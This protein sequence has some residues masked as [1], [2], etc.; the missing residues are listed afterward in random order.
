MISHNFRYAKLQGRSFKGKNLDGANFSNADIRGADFTNA[1]LIGAN[2]KYAKAGLQRRWV[3]GLIIGSWF[4]AAIAGFIS[5]YSSGFAIDILRQQ[6]F[7]FFSSAVSLIIWG[8]FLLV[9]FYKG[10]GAA[11]GSLAVTVATAMAILAAP[12][13]GATFVNSIVLPIAVA[14]NVAGI[15]DGAIALAITR[16]IVKKHLNY[17]L[18]TQLMIALVGTLF[19]VTFGLTGDSFQD[20][21]LAITIAIATAIFLISA[22]T[23]IGW[24]AISEN[25]KY[26]IIKSVAISVSA[27]FGTKFQGANLTDANFTQATLK[28][29]DFR[30][31]TLKRTR[32]FNAKK[33]EQAYV[34]GTYLANETIRKLII[35]KDG[36]GRD[37]NY[38]NM[39]GINLQGANLKNAS[40]IE[41]N[42]SE[43]TLE[44]SNLSQAKL[45]R[46]QLYGTNLGSACLTGAYIQDWGISTDT[47]FSKVECDYIFMRLPTDNDP[48]P[49]RKPDNKSETFKKGDFADFITPII[50]TLDLYQKQNFDP[51]QVA[52]Q[53]KS[54][55][56]YH[57]RGIDPTAAT[58]AIKKIAAKYPESGLKVVALEGRGNEKIRLQAEVTG[59]ANRSELSQEYF[60]TYEQMVSLP[61][62]NLE[63]LLARMAEKDAQIRNLSNLVNTAIKGEKFY[64]ET[65]YQMGD[66]MSEK[67]E[68]NINTSGDVIGVAAGDQTI[69][70]VLGKI[71]GNVNNAINQL[72]D[73]IVSDKPGIKELIT[74][75][76]ALIEADTN[77]SD[78]DKADTL[79]QLQVLAE[80]GKQP[81]EKENQQQAKGAIRFLRGL[82]AELPTATALVEGFNKLIPAITALLSI[83]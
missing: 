70:G 69:S 76:K 44:K 59:G 13:H 4:L 2:F 68:I 27:R 14:I 25:D 42:L 54:L 60:E 10:L 20:L 29:T 8:L 80:A 6:S 53:F 28:N 83:V 48:D 35:T 40:F 5:G 81:Q 26:S 74:Q 3:I 41:A 23:Y 30:Q 61:S 21:I 65:Y 66:S 16:Q 47:Q 7:Y 22:S 79:K 38:Q 15:V 51:R 34:E 63:A 78:V 31:S 50:K 72:P 71:S 73:S 56:L 39:S 19:G 49:C 58:I 62:D 46:T 67:R 82:V 18:L 43:T 52:S 64:V 9:A 1:S 55:D 11:L 36:E 77:L 12:A 33:I 17:H 24:Q 37:F 57:Y 75:L 45:V 32:W